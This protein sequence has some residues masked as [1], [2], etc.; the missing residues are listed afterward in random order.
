MRKRARRNGGLLITVRLMPPESFAQQK[1]RQRG[2]TAWSNRR[3]NTARLFCAMIEAAFRKLSERAWT[4]NNVRR[5]RNW[6]DYLGCFSA[7]IDSV[8]RVHCGGDLQRQPSAE[9][10]T[11]DQIRSGFDGGFDDGLGRAA[12]RRILARRDSAGGRDGKL[13]K[14][15]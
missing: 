8:D 2:V 9:I 10:R 4:N 11:P 6:R 3:R 13:A 12:S 5:W 7:R 1:G 14:P 15:Q